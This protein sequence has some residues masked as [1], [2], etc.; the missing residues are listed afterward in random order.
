MR[1]RDFIAF[2]GAALAIAPLSVSA[3]VTGR[4]PLVAYLS[5]TTPDAAAERFEPFRQAMRDLGWIEGSNYDLVM[6]STEGDNDRLPRLTQEL[7]ARRPDVLIG[8]A[9]RGAIAAAQATATVPIVG[10]SIVEPSMI[11]L[12]GP[13]F[14]HPKGNVTGVLF[15]DATLAKVFELAVDIIPGAKRFVYVED[16]G[17]PKASADTALA[18]SMRT[19]GALGRSLARTEATSPADFPLVIERCLAERADAVVFYGAL[20]YSEDLTSL[21][22]KA[23]LPSF[24]QYS[25]AVRFGGLAAYGSELAYNY[26]RAAAYVDRL[27]KG[28]KPSDL[29][30]EVP[31][32]VL[33]VNLKTARA[34]GITIPQE[35]LFRTDVVVE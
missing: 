20:F 15:S 1:R 32:P 16:T 24:Y 17:V 21:V 7:L 34:L 5:I 2:A 13:N 11:D 35:V 14:A 12:A 23:R 31:R 25:L 22:A 27:L 33:A 6:Q 26:R 10:P 19:V 18:D 8:E 30:I 3:Q 9:T 4:R 28:A 29:P